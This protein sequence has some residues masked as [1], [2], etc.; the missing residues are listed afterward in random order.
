LSAR[1]GRAGGR[2]RVTKRI[3]GSP[4]KKVMIAAGAAG[5]LALS[6]LAALAD[7]A[8]G[9]ISSIDSAGGSITLSDGKVYFL[10]QNFAALSMFKVGD[11]VKMTVFSD[12]AG[13]MN[14]IDLMPDT[15]APASPSPG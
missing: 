7:D 15:S 13:K 6:S 10:P 1:G 2:W 9:T 3:E 12:Q 11:K 8:S 14:V 4:M 5:L